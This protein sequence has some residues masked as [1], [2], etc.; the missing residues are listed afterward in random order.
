MGPVFAMTDSLFNDCDQK[1]LD[2]MPFHQLRATSKLLQALNAD[3]FTFE[4]ILSFTL[5]QIAMLLKHLKKLRVLKRRLN[6]LV[7]KQVRFH[8]EV[9]SLCL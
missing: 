2:E 5:C 3:Y 6:L 8:G 4:R 1:Q 9:I 7:H